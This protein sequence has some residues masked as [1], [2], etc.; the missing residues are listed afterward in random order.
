MLTTLFPER[1]ADE[2]DNALPTQQLCRTIGA[3]AR[4]E[5]P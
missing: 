5:R 1:H 4:A 2:I 3:D